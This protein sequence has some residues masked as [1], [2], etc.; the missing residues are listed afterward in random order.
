[1]YEDYLTNILADYLEKQAMLEE[2]QNYLP[3]EN[4]EKQAMLERTQRYLLQRELEKQAMLEELEKNLMQKELIRRNFLEKI[5]G[6]PPT[7]KKYGL[8]LGAGLGALGLGLYSLLDGEEAPSSPPTELEQ[9]TEHG[10]DIKSLLTTLALL[11]GL[12]AAGYGAYNM[13]S[14]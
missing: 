8:P 10:G 13:F 1:M 5:A 2:L 11:G 9:N 7:V 3:Q 14:D 6:I 12:G 4:L